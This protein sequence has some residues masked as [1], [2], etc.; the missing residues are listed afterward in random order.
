MTSAF[1]GA[2]EHAVALQATVR[3]DEYCIEN[4]HICGLFTVLSVATGHG[5]CQAS[6]F[7][8]RHGAV[9]LPFGVL[10]LHVVRRV[11]GLEARQLRRVRSL[12]YWGCVLLRWDYGVLPVCCNER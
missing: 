9:A 12:C 5:R 10:S 3:S 1:T 8:E 11:V 6:G 2:V 4:D 7:A